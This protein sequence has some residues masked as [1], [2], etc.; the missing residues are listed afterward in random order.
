MFS[1]LSFNGILLLLLLLLLTMS[2]E[3]EYI[4]EVG[5][6]A[7][8]PCSYNPISS[9]SLVPVCWGK[10]SCPVFGCKDLVLSTDETN[11]KDQKSS[12]YQLKGNLHKGDVSLTIVNV[13]PADSG[14]YCCRIQFRGPMNDYK[15]NV[16]LIIKPAKVNPAPT[17]QRDVTTVL[18]RMLTTEGHGSVETQTLGTFHDKN[19]TQISTFADEFQSFG[20]TTRR[21]LYI[22]VGISAGLAL[23]LIFSALILK[24]YS[25]RKK[26]LQNSSLITLANPRPSGL[27]NAAADRMRSEENIYIIEENIYEMED[28]NEDY[29]Y[30]SSE[31]QY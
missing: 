31:Q 30:I 26:K 19:Q 21:G 17:A 28:P 24:W 3:G 15:L 16:E 7:S 9:E 23:T 13:T 22:G 8:L 6:D 4:V 25:H 27:A 18:P 12:R 5:Q 20:A 1:H 10:E 11:V 29:C 2:S 14:T